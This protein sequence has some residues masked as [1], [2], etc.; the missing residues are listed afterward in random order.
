[1]DYKWN[2]PPE[3]IANKIDEHKQSKLNKIDAVLTEI[4][5][6]HE[7]DVRAHTPEGASP[8]HLRDLIFANPVVRFASRF[9]EVVGHTSK[10]GDF[11]EYDTG[12]HKTSA[13]ADDFKQFLAYWV[14]KKLGITGKQA[15]SVAYLIRRKIRKYGTKGKKMFSNSFQQYKDVNLRRLKSIMDTDNEVLR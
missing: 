5:L 6:R 14:E 1:M 3:E 4:G 7:T 15:I 11:V 10:H 8:I 12:P 13:G 2:I 9:E